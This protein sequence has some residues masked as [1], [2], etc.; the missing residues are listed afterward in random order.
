MT[1][2]PHAL[3]PGP[4]EYVLEPPIVFDPA[5]ADWAERTVYDPTA[6]PPKEGA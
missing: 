5:M 6:E 4:S 1:T 3:M 2:N